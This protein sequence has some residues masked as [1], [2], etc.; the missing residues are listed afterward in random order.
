MASND[1]SCIMRHWTLEDG[2][3]STEMIPDS[4]VVLDDAATAR[5]K[6]FVDAARELFFANGYAGTTMSS[7]ASKVGG[8]RKPR[9]G[10]IFR[11]REG[12]TVRSGGRYCRTLWR[13]TGHRPAA[14]RAGPRRC[15]GS[16]MC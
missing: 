11:G 9:S 3:L 10:P 4:T 14:R 8:A 12:G 1:T 13:R 16:A 7:I 2:L 15:A 5:R 6:A